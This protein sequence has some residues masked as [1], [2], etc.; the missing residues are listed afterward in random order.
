MDRIHGSVAVAAVFLHSAC[1]ANAQID[2][3]TLSGAIL[4]TF[5]YHNAGP[6][7][8]TSSDSEA[9]KD[10]RRLLEELSRVIWIFH[11]ASAQAEPSADVTPALIDAQTLASL[12]EANGV[13]T[14]LDQ[15]ERQAGFQAA[16]ELFLLIAQ[17]PT[18]FSG[19]FWASF[20]AILQE[21]RNDLA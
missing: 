16:G 14:D 21:I 3:R 13:R 1:G 18:L 10:M 7:A 5:S 11:A 2:I 6:S 4:Q 17:H 19:P 12:Y 9:L 8:S 20:C 15:A